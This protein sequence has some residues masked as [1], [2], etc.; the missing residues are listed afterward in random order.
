MNKT[1]VM[2]SS[3][4]VL[5]EERRSTVTNKYKKREKSLVFGL[6][7][8]IMTSIRPM[9]AVEKDCDKISQKGT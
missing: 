8:R 2:S 7:K 3:G 5:V 9:E 1:S 4:N 6:Y